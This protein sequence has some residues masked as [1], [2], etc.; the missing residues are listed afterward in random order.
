MLHTFA[1]KVEPLA[2]ALENEGEYVVVYPFEFVAIEVVY[3]TAKPIHECDELGG[4][5]AGDI[6]VPHIGVAET[7]AVGRHCPAVGAFKVTL[8]EM[9][10]RVGNVTV[11][12]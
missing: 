11:P 10:I 6:I 1:A 2:G 8:K 4:F 9:V 3:V 5:Q 7:T 12:E